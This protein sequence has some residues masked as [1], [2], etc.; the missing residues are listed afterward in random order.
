MIKRIKT[1]SFLLSVVL[2]SLGAA[3]AI[4]VWT[5]P[6]ATPPTGNPEPPINVSTSP[7]VKTGIVSA[8][9]FLDYNDPSYYLMDETSN[10]KLQGK[11]SFN[12]TLNKSTG[13]LLYDL[14]DTH[15]NSFDPATPDTPAT[16]TGLLNETYF[17]F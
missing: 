17:P 4:A 9:E 5:G 11:V 1:L 6:S 2:V 12:S 16:H 10:M 13:E 15:A 3:Y 7:Q 14:T 8:K